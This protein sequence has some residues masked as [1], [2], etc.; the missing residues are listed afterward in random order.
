MFDFFGVDTQCNVREFVLLFCLVSFVCHFLCVGYSCLFASV[1]FKDNR[2]RCI[3]TFK[4]YYSYTLELLL[5][6][7][8][9]SSY[10]VILDLLRLSPLTI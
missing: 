10:Q 7:V 3:Y 9:V 8:S 2:H 4:T 5:F 6:T 1:C